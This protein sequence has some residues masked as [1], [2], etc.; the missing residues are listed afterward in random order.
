M[1]ER[2]AKVQRKQLRQAKDDLS[3]ARSQIKIL[4]KKL[5][6]AK[7][8]KEQA[9][10]EGYEVGVAE[11][12]EAPRVEVAEVRR[13]YCLQVWNE[14][15]NQTG[16]KASSALR[17][18]E[19]VYYPPQAI[20]NS[21]SSGSKANPV[22]SR[23]DEGKESPTKA[24]PSTNISS[25]D[26]KPSEDAKKVA[27]L[28]KEAARD[29]ALPLVAPKDSSKDKEV[30]QSMEIMLATL[31]IPSKEELQGKGQASTTTASTQS[32]KKPKDKLVIKMKP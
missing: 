17:R 27:D 13:F 3:A 28:T 29:A 6:E 5:E 24:L 30:S 2:Q 8:A 14:V 23:I 11:T 12:E 21:S 10:Q 4:N 1:A 15:L 7:K 22:S 20:R 26:V 31:P 16:V 18:V 32:P 25:K 9:K 19:N